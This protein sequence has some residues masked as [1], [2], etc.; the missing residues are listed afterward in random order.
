MA[1]IHAEKVV[2]AYGGNQYEIGGGG[3]AV[4]MPT[5]SF[6]GF[7]VV[8]Y[9]TSKGKK[10]TDKVYANLTKCD[11]S[12]IVVLKCGWDITNRGPF[13]KET[14]VL[15]ENDSI[16]GYIGKGNLYDTS[17]PEPTTAKVTIGIDSGGIYFSTDTSLS[18][19]YDKYHLT[20][21]WL[22]DLEDTTSCYLFFVPVGTQSQ[23][24]TK[25][26]ATASSG[27]SLYSAPAPQCALVEKA[28]VNSTMVEVG[29][30]GFPLCLYNASTSYGYFGNNTPYG[31]GNAFLIS[32]PK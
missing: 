21:I 10:V 6:G 16:T 7:N 28:S 31:Y 22:R 14:I 15:K 27:V 1:Q 9:S 11:T 2:L 8:D 5:P 13:Y 19:G 18:F 26:T 17:M 23:T 24:G 29:Y 4:M 12:K 30:I 25:I 32:L 20:L 3:N